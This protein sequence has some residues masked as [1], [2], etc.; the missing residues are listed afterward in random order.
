ML[1]WGSHT[2]GAIQLV[3]AR[4]KKQLKTKIGLGLFT[5]VRTQMVCLFSIRHIINLPVTTNE[6]TRLS[7][8]SRQEQLL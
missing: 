7:T 4:G 1:N 3:K 5:A 8:A 6:T 2:E